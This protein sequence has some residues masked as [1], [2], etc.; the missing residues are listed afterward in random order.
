MNQFWCEVAWI[1][2]EFAEGV[3]IDCDEAGTITKVV[4]GTTCPPTAT[5]L[6]GLTFPGLAN[7]HSH[8]F[9]RALRGRTHGDSFWTWRDSMYELAN[10]LD[11]DSYLRLATAVFAEMALSGFTVAGEFHYLHH[12]PGGH[13]YAEPNAMS[14]AVVEAA[15]AAGLRLTLLDSCYFQGGIGREL[16]PPQRRF[17]D[18]SSEAWAER[19]SLLKETSG[20]RVGAAIHSIRAVPRDAL[21]FIARAAQGQPL[22]VHLSEQ[23]AENEQS[24]AAYGMSP[25]T[26]FAE[27]GVLNRDVTAVHAI[28]LDQVDIETL[29]NHGVRACACP[30]TEADLGDGIGPFSNLAQHGVALALGTDQHV[31]IDPFLEVQRLELDQRLS[32]GQ[33]SVFSAE[34]LVNALTSNGYRSLGWDTGGAIAVNGLCDLTSI[35]TNSP[36]TAGVP[37]AAAVMA[38]SAADVENVI[39]GGR[40]IVTN[41]EHYLGD[42]SQ[43]L[44][45]AIDPLLQS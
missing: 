18:D 36:R 35:K 3:L 43:L 44:T 7:A 25:T 6:G 24:F 2:G 21:S 31:H 23:V 12:Q 11:P 9:H 13:P 20:V 14:D 19:H 22:H 37:L 17:A 40:P 1:G 32:N 41:G 4:R 45:E 27:E 15:R 5:S 8:A 42:I 28:H 33:R 26:V 10:R 38:A 29:A 39:V 34:N 16:E 30:S